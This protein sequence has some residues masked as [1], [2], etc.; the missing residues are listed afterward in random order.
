[1]VMLWLS[2]VYLGLLCRVLIAM[3]LTVRWC[4]GLCIGGLD[5]CYD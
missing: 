2:M 1:M 3:E 4:Q 5:D